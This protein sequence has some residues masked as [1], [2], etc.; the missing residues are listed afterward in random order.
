MLSCALFT[1]LWGSKMIFRGN[2]TIRGYPPPNLFHRPLFYSGPPYRF[3][4]SLQ[5]GGWN[6]SNVSGF[7]QWWWRWMWDSK[8]SVFY[9]SPNSILLE[10]SWKTIG[11]I[12]DTLT[13]EKQ[14]LYSWCHFCT[15]INKFVYG[16]IIE[17]FTFKVLY[18]RIFERWEWEPQK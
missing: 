2:W 8:F 9:D 16:Q 14:Y 15:R 7:V 10:V 1:K 5:N 13:Y 18:C 6:S 12:G 17:N 11:N 4:F 3:S